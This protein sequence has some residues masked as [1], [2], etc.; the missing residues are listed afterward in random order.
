MCNKGDS[1]EVR[2]LKKNVRTRNNAYQLD[3]FRLREEMGK[4]W[5]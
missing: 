3:Y 1:D 4:N 2:M 5:L